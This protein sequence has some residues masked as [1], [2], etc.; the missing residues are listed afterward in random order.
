MTANTTSNLRKA[1][2]SPLSSA[3]IKMFKGRKVQKT[4][5][6]DA[7]QL[8]QNIQCNMDG[9]NLDVSTN[10]G[11]HVKADIHG[12]QRKSYN[13]I[14]GKQRYGL[15]VHSPAYFLLVL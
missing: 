5:S 6:I 11:V 9:I 10:G 7:G 15:P 14:L 13:G 12:R 2:G 8:S 3:E 4:Y 1:S